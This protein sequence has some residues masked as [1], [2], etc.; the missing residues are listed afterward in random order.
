MMIVDGKIVME[1]RKI[2]TVDEE[3]IVSKANEVA[4]RIWRKVEAEIGLPKL[5][6]EKVRKV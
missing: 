2:L 6:L 3:E 4:H 5:L 1:G